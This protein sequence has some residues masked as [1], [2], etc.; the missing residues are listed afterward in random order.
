LTINLQEPSQQIV[1]SIDGRSIAFSEHASQKF[2][3]ERIRACVQYLEELETNIK[4]VLFIPAWIA[5]KDFRDEMESRTE[6]HKVT[7][8][9]GHRSRDD[10]YALGKTFLSDG[11]IVTNDKRMHE[12]SNNLLVDRAWV[13]SRRIGFRFGKGPVFI[14]GFPERW[15]KACAELRT[16][17]DGNE[18]VI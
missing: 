14:P 7:G 17:R 18:E 11:F 13:A 9:N 4:I 15:H 5:D 10:E 8:I 1:V 3:F 12:H 2:D 16:P 6:L